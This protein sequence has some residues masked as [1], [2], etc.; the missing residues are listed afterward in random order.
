[1]APSTDPDDVTFLFAAPLRRKSRKTWVGRRDIEQLY[2][3]MKPW[4]EESFSKYQHRRPELGLRGYI[5]AQPNA[6]VRAAMEYVFKDRQ[7]T[8][9]STRE[10]VEAIRRCGAALLQLANRPRGGVVFFVVD[11]YHKSSF[12]M[13]LIMMHV[14]FKDD[15]SFY[16]RMGIILFDDPVA[17]TRDVAL[18]LAA[19]PHNAKNMLVFIDDAAYSGLQMNGFVSGVYDTFQHLMLE[20]RFD[21]VLC[22]PYMSR[23]AHDLL[24]PRFQWTICHRVFDNIF[25]DKRSTLKSV[26][27][28]DLYFRF[29]G[30]NVYR[31]LYFDVMGLTPDQS[32]M[33][34]EHKI[35][36]AVSI[37]TKLLFVGPCFPVEVDVAYK[38]KPDF[39]KMYA[40]KEDIAYLS[41]YSY[42][43][44]EY[45]TD[46]PKSFKVRMMRSVKLSTPREAQH[47]G[48]KPMLEPQYC[49]NEKYQ[50]FMREL[51]SEGYRDPRS[52]HRNYIWIP[53]CFLPPY[54]SSTYKKLIVERRRA[55][56]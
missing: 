44:C 13:L 40:L 7:W 10:L 51:L 52:I 28:H 41:R 39:F 31:S 49:T 37:P 8:Y 45:M 9:V 54:K 18:R 3:Q 43:I 12:W 36:D 48:F 14:F 46:H 6:A 33:L 53:D 5:E 32:M 27:L 17:S 42:I 47:V 16:D 34:F 56:Q 24:R 20:Q 22:V 38:L 4:I 50:R 25:D 21:Y 35:P 1:M 23:R 2:R 30:S 26:L 55:K 29:P 15:R 11:S 19:L